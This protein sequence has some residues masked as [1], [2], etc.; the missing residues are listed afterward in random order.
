MQDQ[1]FHKKFFWQDISLKVFH[2][3]LKFIIMKN[4]SKIATAIFAG[5]AAG[6]AVWY[7]MSTDDGKKKWSCFVDDV[8]D[9]KDTL[10]T[11]ASQTA[12]DLS[13][14]AD[15]VGD[16]INNKKDSLKDYA[17]SKMHQGANFA[18][19]KANEGA[20]YAENKFNQGKDF[21]NAKYDDAKDFTNS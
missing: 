19:E 8:K 3:K 6:A 4:N 14:H 2:K 12:S 15:K 5:L 9:L 21:A 20:N 18:T 13:T 11:K 16:Y 17:N 1:L 7:F 10:K